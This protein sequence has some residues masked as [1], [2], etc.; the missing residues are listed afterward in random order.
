MLPAQGDGGLEGSRRASLEGLGVFPL[1]L[2]E[3]ELEKKGKK[4]WRIGG[5]EIFE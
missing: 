1:S 4:N 5:M 2:I 3:R